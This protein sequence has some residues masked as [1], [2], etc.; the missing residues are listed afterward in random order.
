MDLISQLPFDLIKPRTHIILRRTRDSAGF[1]E[2][3]IYAPS[4]PLS[5]S[6]QAVV[7]PVIR[8]D[9]VSI[10]PEDLRKR[11]V[12]RIFSNTQLIEHIDTGI[13]AADEISYG[14]ESY[15]VFR[16]GSWI[17]VNGFSGYEAYAVRIDTEELQLL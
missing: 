9:M 11:K 6:I 3:G 2:D 15:R 13:Y 14:G 1:N 10:L 16:L 12:I 5:I 8:S 7:S 17:N 4:T